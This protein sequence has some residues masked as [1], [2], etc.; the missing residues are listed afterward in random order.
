MRC[1]QEAQI[2]RRMLY[3][4]AMRFLRNTY[5]PIHLVF[6]CLLMALLVVFSPACKEYS[7]LPVEKPELKYRVWPS[8]PYSDCPFI[9]STEIT[10]VAFTGRHKEYAETAADTWYPSWA[11]DGNMYS[12]FADGKVGDIK[13]D[14][15]LYGDQKKTVT[16]G[17]AKIVGDDPMNL[18]VIAIGSQT[19]FLLPY[20]ARYPT[21]SL[22][23]NGIWYYGTQVFDDLWGTCGWACVQGPFVGFSIS[24]D[25]G[26]IWFDPVLTPTR[27]LFGETSMNGAKVKMGSPHFVDFGKN[28]EHSP[29]GKAYLVAHGATRPEAHNSVF[30][31]DAIYLS[32]VSPTP[33][34]INDLSKYEFFA[35]YDSLTRLPKWSRKFSDVQ[36]L[37]D[38]LDRTG[39]VSITYDAPLKKYLMCVT[40]GWPTVGTFDTYIL[41]ADAAAIV[42]PNPRPMLSVPWRLVTFMRKFGEQAYFV[43][44]PS[45]FVSSDGRTVW[46]C[47]TN[48]YT[49]NHAKNPP[50]GPGALVLQ[51]IKLLGP[52]GKTA[53]R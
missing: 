1:L 33:E 36:P 32:R 2:R 42:G 41:E 13:V 7:P 3:G 39:P 28:M 35:G 19:A 20:Y 31:G 16:F 43:N 46:L 14:C 30:S 29:D 6:Y 52:N 11:A 45:K 48:D 5:N 47:Y 49:E 38:W 51:E 27:N 9:N 53:S 8:E 26:K 40:H 21:A 34:N 37:F 4:E 24:R 44:I 23:Y 15:K 12:P 10:G 22:V 17:Q 18:E 25:Y 50:V